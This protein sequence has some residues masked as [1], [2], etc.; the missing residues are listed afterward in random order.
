MSDQNLK[1]NIKF[2]T[3]WINEYPNKMTNIV[4]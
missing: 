4:N 3:N 2:V 1:A